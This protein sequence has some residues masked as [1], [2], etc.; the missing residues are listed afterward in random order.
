MSKFKMVIL[1]LFCFMLSSCGEH[2]LESE[3]LIDRGYDIIVTFDSNGG[4]FGSSTLKYIYAAEGTILPEPGTSTLSI[5]TRSGYNIEGWYTASYDETG[6][7]MID[8]DGKVVLLDK[9]DFNTSVSESLVLYA[10]W[11]KNYVYNVNFV[12]EDL[13]TYNLDVAEY[14]QQIIVSNDLTFLGSIGNEVSRVNYSGHTLIDMNFYQDEDCTVL[15]DDDFV[16]PCTDEETDV[17]IYAKVAKGSFTLASSAADFQSWKVG[18]SYYL[19]N[20]IDFTGYNFEDL[21][22]FVY[23]SGTIAGNGYSFINLDYS[24][25][26]STSYYIGLFTELYEAEMYNLTFKDCDILIEYTTSGKTNLV[27]NVGFLAG[28]VTGTTLKNIT[29]EDCSINTIIYG[30][31]L[32]TFSYT[33][34]CTYTFVTDPN[35][36]VF[37]NIVGVVS[38]TEEKKESGSRDSEA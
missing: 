13:E 24:V 3:N 16:H 9:W 1:L 25:L 11:Q 32:Y 34:D 4:T 38:Y 29:F 12:V 7:V 22:S 37:Q 27:V 14:V 23:Y 10:N 20:D 36:S 2:E 28:K 33:E 17:E 31:L 26:D 18:T 15:W 19:L 30:D 21:A 6:E 8:E 5:A 35:V